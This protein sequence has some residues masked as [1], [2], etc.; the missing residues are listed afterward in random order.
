MIIGSIPENVSNTHRIFAD[1]IS[2]VKPNHK[3]YAEYSV[4]KLLQSYW[5]NYSIPVSQRDFYINTQTKL[6]HFDFYDETFNIVFEIQGEQHRKFNKFFHESIGEF[7]I[8]NR[9]D[10]LK[11]LVCNITNTKL[12][13][14]DVNQ[15]ITEELLI[16]Y[17]KEL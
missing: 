5:Y 10:S 14:I 4:K 12:V 8:Q 2:K 1:L 17:Y 11:K 7:D 13:E 9:N 6:L 3:I 15:K 16:S